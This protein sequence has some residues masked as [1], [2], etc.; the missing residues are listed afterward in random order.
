MSCSLWP[1]KSQLEGYEVMQVLY[2]F[3]YKNIFY[4][5]WQNEKTNWMKFAFSDMNINYK[6]YLII[7]LMHN[8]QI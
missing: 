8:V 3:A 7:S 2:I 5:F 1:Q 4:I 6:K